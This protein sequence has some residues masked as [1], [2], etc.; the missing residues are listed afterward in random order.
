MW[1]IY[2]GLR[3]TD[4][5]LKAL[6]RSTLLS[7]FERQGI[8]DL[9]VLAGHQ[10]AG[11]SPTARG[12]YF[13]LVENSRYGWQHRKDRYDRDS[14]Q[15]CHSETQQMLSHFQL[16]GYA[17]FNPQ[18][19]AATTAE[20]LTSLAAMLISSQAFIEALTRHGAGLQRIT[21]IRCPYFENDQGQQEAAPFFDFTVSH[22]RTITL[23]A[24]SVDAI[25][26]A[27]TRV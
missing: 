21:V 2:E 26:Q 20:D 25:E 8:T 15:Q 7:L 17:Q 13:F 24:P 6:I 19:P 27:I 1:L 12:L 3:M 4:N 9:P 5:Q 10:P 11:Q 22:S 18:D 16:G 23:S 14:G